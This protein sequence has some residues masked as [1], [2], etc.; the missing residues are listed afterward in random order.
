MDTPENQFYVYAYLRV[1]GTPYYIGKGSGERC[2]RDGGRPCGPP[3]DRSRISKLVDGLSEQDAFDLEE[4]MISGLGRKDIETGI[5]HNRSSGGEGNSG[6]I[7]SQETIAKMSA[8]AKNRSLRHNEK[9]VEKLRRPE[10]QSKRLAALRSPE[11]RAKL[12]AARSRNWVITTPLGENLYVKNLSQF[13]REN[14]LNSGHMSRVA[15]GSLPQ[16]K[17]FKVAH[18]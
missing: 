1:D 8:A 16:H 6:R 2:Y 3:K 4:W 10:V 9:I 7:V 14:S 5:L 17:G 18:A 12:S 15:S 13:C 11:V